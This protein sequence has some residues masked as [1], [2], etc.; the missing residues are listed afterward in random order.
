MTW[1]NLMKIECALL[2]V[3]ERIFFTFLGH[4]NAH[5]PL[6]RTCKIPSGEFYSRSQPCVVVAE[7]SFYQGK[8]EQQHTIYT[9]FNPAVHNTLYRTCTTTLTTRR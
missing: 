9:M 5:N 3:Q 1:R 8:N 2:A 4:P 6:Y 7:H